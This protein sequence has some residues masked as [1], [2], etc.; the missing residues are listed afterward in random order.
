MLPQMHYFNVKIPANF[1]GMCVHLHGEVDNMNNWHSGSGLAKLE[2][3]K[4]FIQ[5]TFLQDKQIFFKKKKKDKQSVV[6][7]VQEYSHL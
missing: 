6:S 4:N 5:I 3:K 2:Y 7:P 1:C